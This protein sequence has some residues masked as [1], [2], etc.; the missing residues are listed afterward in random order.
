[1]RAQL[2]KQ[3]IF[4][5]KY[6]GVIFPPEGRD[7]CPPDKL[8][9][10]FPHGRWLT[11]DSDGSG[12][13]S[14]SLWGSVEADYWT[15]SVNGIR[16]GQSGYLQDPLQ[17]STLLHTF[18]D[19]ADYLPKHCEQRIPFWNWNEKL[20]TF[21]FFFGLSRIYSNPE[22]WR[23]TLLEIMFKLCEKKQGFMAL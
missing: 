16:A 21:F 23:E 3:C 9:Q 1:M 15:E 2:S 7:R 22:C 20:F 5:R 4:L 11:Q 12:C 8:V 18:Q 10:G 14:D 13:L 6:L 19:E 17:P